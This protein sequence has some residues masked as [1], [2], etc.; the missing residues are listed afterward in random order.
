M[1]V[2]IGEPIPKS[3]TVHS[4][5]EALMAAKELGRYP[6]LVRPAYT[7]GGTGGGIAYN[8]EELIT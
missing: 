8:D 2:K 6:V 7:L 4:V 1:M 5:N 3:R